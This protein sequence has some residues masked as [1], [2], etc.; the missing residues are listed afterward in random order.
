MKTKIIKNDLD[1]MMVKNEARNT[2][3]KEPTQN[4]VTDDFKWRMLISEHSP[5]RLLRLVWKWNDIPYYSSVHFAR[6]VTTEK[7]V[8]TSRTDRTGVDRNNLPQN[9]PVNMDM[10]ANAQSLINMAKFRLCYKADK[11]TREYMENLKDTIAS[12]DDVLGKVLVP[13]CVRRCGCTEPVSCN[14]WTMFLIWLKAY[15]P[16]IDIANLSVKERYILWDAY[17]KECR[18]RK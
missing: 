3:G 16:K 5:I 4:E 14:R 17:D 18:K 9:N 11:T 7:W 8:S 10:E 12:L 2:M 1:W 6:H 15:N 13:E